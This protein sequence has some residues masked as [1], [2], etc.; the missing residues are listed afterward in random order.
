MPV[1]DDERT[2][3]GFNELIGFRRVEWEAGHAVLELAIGPQHL[4]R[5]GTLHGGVLST[6]IDTACGY[7]G[8][9]CARPGRVRK[10][11][12]LSLTTSFTGQAGGGTIRAVGRLRAGGRRIYVA[13]AEIFNAEGELIAIGESTQRYRT[14]SESP[15]GVPA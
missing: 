6:L 8:C 5:S 13:T 7:A 11:V 12:S 9:Y 2:K 14:G 3:S 4:N 1:I 10:A 15:E